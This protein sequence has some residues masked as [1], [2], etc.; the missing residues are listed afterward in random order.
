MAVIRLTKE[1]RFEMAHALAGYN[2]PCR[3]IHGHSYEFM[4]TISGEPVN[5]PESPIFGMVM[6]FKELKQLVEK[7]IISQFDHALVL[8][9]ETAPDQLDM[10]GEFVGRLILT[11]YPPTSENML[12]DFSERLKDLLPSHINLL[13]LRLRETKSSWAEWYACDNN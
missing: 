1:F 8:H 9:K 13:S 11:D 5:N 2:G 12:I 4:I 3:H 7:E 10:M 6:D